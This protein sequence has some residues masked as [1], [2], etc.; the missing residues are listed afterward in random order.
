MSLSYK[1]ILIIMS[2]AYINSHALDLRLYTKTRVVYIDT[3]QGH[4]WAITRAVKRTQ[5]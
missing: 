1:L 5:A 2:N 3:K 4:S